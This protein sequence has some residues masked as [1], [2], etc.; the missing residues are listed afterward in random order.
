MF[1]CCCELIPQ[2]HT[3]SSFSSAKSGQPVPLIPAVELLHGKVSPPAPAL[4]RNKQVPA[5]PIQFS[6][7]DPDQGEKHSSTVW[8]VVG[9][10]L[11]KQPSIAFMLQVAVVLTHDCN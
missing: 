4:L 9:S 3:P 11:R 5:K 8:E 1:I 10:F 6:R 2:P 7:Q